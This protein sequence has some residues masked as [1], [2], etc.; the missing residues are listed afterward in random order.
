MTT[1]NLKDY[2]AWYSHDEYIEVPDDVAQEL[3][4][5]TLYEAAYRRKVIRNKAQ[6]SLDCDDGIEY[7]VCLNQRRRSC[8]SAWSDFTRCGTRSTRCRKYRGVAWTLA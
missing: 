1:I 3:E 7:S 8:W 5:D 2:F 4:E 6:Y